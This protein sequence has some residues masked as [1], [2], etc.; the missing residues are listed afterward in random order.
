MIEAPRADEDTNGHAGNGC[1]NG[2]GR[3]EAAVNGNGH[4]HANGN[5]HAETNGR[6][7]ELFVLNGGEN[8]QG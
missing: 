6:R 4:A 2:N 3:H 7:K 8:L 5:G 1:C